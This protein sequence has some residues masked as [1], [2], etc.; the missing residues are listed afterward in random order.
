M[1]K[2]FENGLVTIA[3]HGITLKEHVDTM[4]FSK[5][6]VGTHSVPITL[7]ATSMYLQVEEKTQ[8]QQQQPVDEADPSLIIKFVG[9][10]DRAASIMKRNFC[11]PKQKCANLQGLF[12]LSDIQKATVIEW[13]ARQGCQSQ[14]SFKQYGASVQLSNFV[15]DFFFKTRG[16]WCQDLTFVLLF[17]WNSRLLLYINM[18][19]KNY[20]CMVY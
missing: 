1:Q 8:V 14:F 15:V 20:M 10:S 2:A 12:A 19:A 11:M 3:E 5:I 18:H 7:M 13:V 6:G 4:T 16:E 9:I 17:C